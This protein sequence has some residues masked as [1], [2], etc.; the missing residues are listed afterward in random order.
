LESTEK[1]FNAARM[2]PLWRDEEYRFQ[3]YNEAI[4]QIAGLPFRNLL[5]F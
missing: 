3:Q 4:P 5:E 1:V 2:F